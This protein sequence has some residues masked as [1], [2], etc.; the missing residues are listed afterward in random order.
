MISALRLSS[1]CNGYIMTPNY[2]MRPGGKAD[3]V[4]LADTINWPLGIVEPINVSYIYT[5]VNPKHRVTKKPYT[6]T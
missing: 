5:D 1:T 4:T 2:L 6:L 3:V